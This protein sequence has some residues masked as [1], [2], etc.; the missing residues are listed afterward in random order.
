[1]KT[2]EADVA[3]GGNATFWEHLDQLR[4]TLLRGI[5]VTGVLAIALFAVMPRLFPEMVMAPCRGD[6]A[7][8]RL[9]EWITARIPVLPEFVSDGWSVEVININL[10]SQFFIHMQLSLIGAVIVAV[11][12]W[13]G[14]LWNFVSPGLYPSERRGVARA[15]WLGG[16]LFY[17]GMAIGYFVVFPLTLRFLADY[18]I[19]AD[20][21]NRISLDS[22]ID[23]FLGMLFAMG[24]VGEIPVVCALLG[25]IGIL[26]RRSFS[27]YR[28]HAAVVLLILAAF[29]TPTG[30]PLTLCVVFVPLYMLWEL[31]GRMIP[32]R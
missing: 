2:S 6:F 7:L 29:I 23:N 5:A 14:L 11:P 3:V 12:V 9:F 16:G 24:L 32:R 15:L 22:Y 13:L 10:A 8:Y 26:S 25:R 21:A 20:I 28:R 4:G 31:G 19:S 1:M 17:I 18:Q 30:D 27:R